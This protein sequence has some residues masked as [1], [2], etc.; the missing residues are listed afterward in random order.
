M[1]PKVQRTCAKSR[2]A[3]TKRGKVAKEKKGNEIFKSYTQGKK[4]GQLQ[5]KKKEKKG[6]MRARKNKHPT[7]KGQRR[8]TFGNGGKTGGNPP[9]ICCSVN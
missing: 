4:G 9:K 6:V 1:V 7:G 3:R 5:G 2:R 8:G